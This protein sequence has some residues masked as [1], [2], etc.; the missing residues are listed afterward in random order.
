MYKDWIDDI[1]SAKKLPDYEHSPFPKP[2]KRSF[3]SGIFVDAYD[4]GD[5]NDDQ[6]GNSA[7]RPTFMTTIAMLFAVIIS[8]ISNWI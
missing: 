5:D 1:M 8:M 3:W 6:H 7:N 2:P 4:D